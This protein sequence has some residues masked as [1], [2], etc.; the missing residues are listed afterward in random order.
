MRQLFLTCLPSI[1]YDNSVTVPAGLGPGETIH[2]NDSSG[3]LF[4]AQ[5]PEG[6]TTGSVF[7]VRAP[8]PCNVVALPPPITPYALPP[9]ISPHVSS[10]TPPSVPMAHAEAVNTYS[11]IPVSQ[12]A[13][14]SQCLDSPGDVPV[15]HHPYKQCIRPLAP[16]TPENPPWHPVRPSTSNFELLK[17]SVPPGAVPGSSIV[18]QVPG[19]NRKIAA[20]IPPNC[21]EFH[22]QY[23]PLAMSSNSNASFHHSSLPE[24]LPGQRLVKVQVPPGLG[25]GDTLHVQIPGEPGRLVRAQ[26]PPGNVREFNVAYYPKTS[27]QY[28][29]QQQEQPQHYSSNSNNHNGGSDTV[30]PVMGGLLAAVAG[31]MAYD[32]F[33]HHNDG[34]GGDADF[35]DADCGN[36][37]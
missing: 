14:F 5:I 21:T 4:A 32:H 7:Y 2:V 24:V 19:E 18:V 10:A 8:P 33:A 22:V 9:P 28:V 29:G 23:Q 12:P 27:Q 6:M 11:D 17:V 34:Y 25:P 26:V 3:R 1:L 31:A 30:L 36:G 16:P 20:K 13:P 35:G 15:A 37:D